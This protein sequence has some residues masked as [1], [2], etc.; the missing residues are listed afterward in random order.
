MGFGNNQKSPGLQRP[1]GAQLIHPHK[2]VGSQIDRPD[3]EKAMMAISNGHTNGKNRLPG[4]TVGVGK[5]RPG[6]V[7]FC[8]DKPYQLASLFSG[9]VRA[10]VHWYAGADA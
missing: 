3:A 6:P 10:K 4:G 5:P 9:H 7:R 2:F 8:F 1:I